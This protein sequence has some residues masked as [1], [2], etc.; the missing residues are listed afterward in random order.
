MLPIKFS[1]WTSFLSD[2]EWSKIYLHDEMSMIPLKSHNKFLTKR[3]LLASHDQQ[4]P[5]VSINP[6]I[7]PPAINSIHENYVGKEK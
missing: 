1:S 7:I 3:F 4:H 5:N 6:T 2:S